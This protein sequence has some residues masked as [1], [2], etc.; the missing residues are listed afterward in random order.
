MN[1]FIQNRLRARF[2]LVTHIRDKLRAQSEGPNNSETPVNPTRNEAGKGYNRIGNPLP[3]QPN[4]VYSQ[5]TIYLEIAFLFLAA[6]VLFSWI[7]SK[8]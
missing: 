8:R 2:P 1:S 4:Y 6:G 3:L 7:K 5:T